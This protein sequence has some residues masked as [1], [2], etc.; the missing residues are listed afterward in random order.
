M[1]MYDPLK[2]C[3]WAHLATNDIRIKKVSTDSTHM[4]LGVVDAMVNVNATRYTSTVP[5]SGHCLKTR[6]ILLQATHSMAN[7]DLTYNI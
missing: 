3:H 2:H 6:M 4:K 7:A 1:N 5:V